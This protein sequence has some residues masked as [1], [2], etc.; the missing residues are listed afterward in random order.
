MFNFFKKIIINQENK[1]F[2]DIMKKEDELAK[3]WYNNNTD[4]NFRA[5]LNLFE[6]ISYLYLNNRID[7]SFVEENFLVIF[8]SLGEEWI[9]KINE[10]TGAYDNLKKMFKIIK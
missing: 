2:F 7:K 9:D 10:F 8:K 5:Y 6:F 1:L 3:A 4:D